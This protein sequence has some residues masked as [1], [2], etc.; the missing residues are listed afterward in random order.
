MICSRIISETPGNSALI[1]P[2][3]CIM[4]AR[5]ALLFPNENSTVTQEKFSVDDEKLC[6]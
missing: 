2:K 1:R 4:Q 5:P 6:Q 3:A